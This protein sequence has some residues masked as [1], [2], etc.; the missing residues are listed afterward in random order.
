[1]FYIFWSFF[2]NN[3]NTYTDIYPYYSVIIIC[4]DIFVVGTGRFN[5]HP[6]RRT[7]RVVL[8]GLNNCFGSPKKSSSRFLHYLELKR[9]EGTRL[10]AFPH[11]RLPSGTDGRYDPNVNHY[12][13]NPGG[14]EMTGRLIAGSTVEMK[15][16]RDR[17]T[18]FCPFYGGDGRLRRM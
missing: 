12:R 8:R 1:L 14:E 11:F 16:I 4:F 3:W 7:H 6:P 17:R 9:P 18:T 13:C 2:T 15:R 5:D 10:L